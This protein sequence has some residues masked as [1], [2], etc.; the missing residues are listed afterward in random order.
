MDLPLLQSKRSK[1]VRDARASIDN[2]R[3][4]M[5]DPFSD[6]DRVSIVWNDRLDP[7]EIAHLSAQGKGPRRQRRPVPESFISR[8]VREFA[9]G[10]MEDMR[11]VPARSIAARERAAGAYFAGIARTRDPGL[12]AY[13]VHL[14]RRCVSG[15]RSLG[16]MLFWR[17][18]GALPVSR[19]TVTSIDEHMSVVPVML[20]DVISALSPRRRVA[21]TM[22]SAL[23]CMV[24]EGNPSRRETHAALCLMTGCSYKDTSI[25]MNIAINTVRKHVASIYHKLAVHSSHE[26]IARDLVEDL[27]AGVREERTTDGYVVMSL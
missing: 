25:R 15:E 3:R 13:D 4:I 12:W 21:D 17:K 26:L 20:V 6:V 23:G 2:L 14:V 1:S 18:A 27:L 16:T 22:E 8:L 5:L 24:D 10:C 19:G 7:G 11:C 9:T